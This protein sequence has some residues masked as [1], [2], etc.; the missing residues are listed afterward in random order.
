MRLNKASPPPQ[1]KRNGEDPRLSFSTPEFKEA[2][3]VFTENFRQ[4]FRREYLKLH[5]PSIARFH[6][7]SSSIYS[8][9][10]RSS[11]VGSGQGISMEYPSAAPLGNTSRK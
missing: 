7:M 10:G 11:R 3:R 1:D 4:N 6:Q 8:Y 2:Q 9:H 5:D